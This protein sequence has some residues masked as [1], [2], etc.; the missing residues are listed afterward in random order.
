MAI[1]AMVPNEAGHLDVRQ[2]MMAV[3]ELEQK[4]GFQFGLPAAVAAENP[5]LSKWQMADQN[6]EA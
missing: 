4:T 3:T 6:R 2:F 1:G 5:V